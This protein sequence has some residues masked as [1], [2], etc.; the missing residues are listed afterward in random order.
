MW[1]HLQFGVWSTELS[2]LSWG[3]LGLHV[4]L[5]LDQE[6][7]SVIATPPITPK[8]SWG[9]TPTKAAMTI[10]IANIG[11]VRLLFFS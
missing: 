10:A 2:A 11:V 3:L 5:V 7:M 9:T 1:S 4:P 8:I 6:V